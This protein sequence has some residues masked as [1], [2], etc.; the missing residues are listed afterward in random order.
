MGFFK[1]LKKKESKQDDMLDLPPLPPLGEGGDNFGDVPLEGDIP[2]PPVAPLPDSV[3]DV[4]F[5]EYDE[6]SDIGNIPSPEIP[7]ESV[8][9][10]TSKPTLSKFLP[11]D[12]AS[13]S[14]APPKSTAFTFVRV[15]TYKNLLDELMS[16]KSDARIAEERLMAAHKSSEF[17]DK[18]ERKLKGDLEDIHKKLLVIDNMLSK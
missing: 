4:P 18:L 15:E 8:P 3:P 17:E 10:E 11:K 5:P 7:G 16:S 1:F 14:F 12:R 13:P 9:M 2:P 6:I